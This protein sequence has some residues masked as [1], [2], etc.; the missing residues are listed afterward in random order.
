[1]FERGAATGWR[2][3]QT[4]NGWQGVTTWKEFKWTLQRSRLV[5]QKLKPYGKDMKKPCAYKPCGEIGHNHKEHKDECPNC[6]GSHPVE[7]CPTRQITCFLCE[8]TTHYPAQCHIYPM[9]QRTIQQKK[10]AMKR[11]LMESLEESVMKEEVEDTPK[12]EPIKPCT[13]SCYSCGEE[14]HISQNCLNGDLVEFPTEEVEYDP[15]EIEAL[16]GTEKSRKKSRLD[17]RNN[18][19]STKRDLSH[20][21]CFRCKNSGHYFNDCPKGKMRTPGGYIITRKPRDMSEVICFRCDEAG[22]FAR[23]CPKET[24]TC[25]K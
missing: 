15:Q 2:M 1:M 4:I 13:K 25:D 11:A 20:I 21:T 22:H 6:E 14:G 7:E 16:I 10:E 24:E 17:P 3:Y 18:P 9:V 5:S 19:I 8:G 23:E 12:E